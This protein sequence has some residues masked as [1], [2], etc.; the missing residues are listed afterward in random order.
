[1]DLIRDATNIQK[2]LKTVGFATY[3]KTYDGVNCN[4]ITQDDLKVI[5]KKLGYCKN[6]I[7]TDE[8]IFMLKK[9][10]TNKENIKEYILREKFDLNNKKISRDLILKYKID[11]IFKYIKNNLNEKDKM[12]VVEIRSFY[13][14]IFKEILLK[15]ERNNIRIYDFYYRKTDKINYSMIYEIKLEDIDIYYIYDDCQRG[16]K[17]ITKDNLKDISKKIYF[18]DESPEYEK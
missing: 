15:N 4:T 8:A 1:M 3:K 6:D 7:Y 12:G 2:G 10:L 16:F 17:K 5:D 11:F 18:F 13:G 9:E 14:K